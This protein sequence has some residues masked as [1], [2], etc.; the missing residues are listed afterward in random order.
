MTAY[1][2][3]IQK[4]LTLI[5]ETK[6]K[7]A[8]RALEKLLQR[9]GSVDGS[10]TTDQ[11]GAS[12]E[13]GTLHFLRILLVDN[14][15]KVL[16][17]TEFDGNIAPYINDF[18]NYT[19]KFFN[20]LVEFI[21]D[22]P[23]APVEENR[24]EFLCWVERHDVPST[25]F[26]GSYPNQTVL[27]IL[28]NA[29]S[30]Y[31][32]QTRSPL[33]EAKEPTRLP[34]EDIQGFI[35]RGYRL[36]LVRHLVLEV[37]DPV[38][39][40]LFLGRLVSGEYGTP[41]IT[42][43]EI[44]TKKPG[45]TLNIGLT[46]EGLK[47]LGLPEASLA[48]FPSEFCQGA[49]NSAERLGDTGE[50]AHEHW[51]GGLH[52]QS[53]H[54]VLTLYSLTDR[55]QDRVSNKLRQLAGDALTELSVF[56]GRVFPDGRVHFGYKD[57]FSQ[58]SI[59]G[60]PGEPKADGQ[61]IAPAGEFLLGYPSQLPGVDHADASENYVYPVPQPECLGLNGSFGVLRVLKQDVA[62]FHAFLSEKSTELKVP[63]KLLAAKICGRWANGV[64][65]ALSPDSPDIASPGSL[66]TYNDFGY[67]ETDKYGA[68]CPIG[69]HI[70]RTN[71]RD[72]R[73]AGSGGHLHRIVRRGVPYGPAFDPNNPDDG[74]ER[75][76]LGY[77]INVSIKDQFEFIMEQ[78]VNGSTFT[79]RI[80]GTRDPLLGSNSIEDSKFNIPTPTQAG[81][82]PKPQRSIEGFPRFIV[83]RGSA[84]CFLPSLSA[85][86]YLASLGTPPGQSCPRGR[87]ARASRGA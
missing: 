40:R 21:A 42:S 26:Q 68:R 73:I 11:R 8:G 81:P 6:S 82:L 16:L 48:S 34:L 86:K 54:I 87:L 35:L 49:A 59:E 15:S 4:P 52:T 14:Y 65:L 36:P 60:A 47:A 78:W 67:A 10:D 31:D 50:S 58:P 74:E 41:Q 22:P 44:W 38:A 17:V 83:T 12:Y 7:K 32:L 24:E 71:P 70:R 84:Y 85:V 55:I 56:D 30:L 72:E 69:A 37:C 9:L 57:G 23:Q 39:A 25:F 28:D 13:I 53:A 3:S 29:G 20:L 77:F 27:D 18:V 62:A 45:F 43:A 61:P 63:R 51:V 33:I 79:P 1:Q 66:D 76:L 64:P 80:A 19:G 5:A 2:K 75:G 46:Y